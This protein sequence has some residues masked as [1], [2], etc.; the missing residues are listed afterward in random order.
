MVYTASP[1][2]AKLMEI[3]P[4]TMSCLPLSTS[5]PYRC[6]L[7][8]IIASFVLSMVSSSVR[9]MILVTAAL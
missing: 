3:L 4:V 5:N 9:F 2:Q 6:C 1:L 8:S 7:S